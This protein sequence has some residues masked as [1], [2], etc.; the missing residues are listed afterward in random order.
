MLLHGEG[1]EF[2]KDN[3]E[4]FESLERLYELISQC[5]PDN[6]YNEDEV[7]LFFRLLPCYA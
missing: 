7:G 1:A 5:K 2:E 3:P 6:V 4:L